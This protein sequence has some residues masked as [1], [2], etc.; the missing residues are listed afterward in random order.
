M[1]SVQN[2]TTAL[3]TDNR[4]P[5]GLGRIKIQYPWDSDSN[6]SYWARVVTFMSG[7]D[8]GSCFLS[9][10]ED[11]VLVAFLDGNIEYPIV[12]GSLWNQD[13]T[14]PYT[15]D[16]EE[17]NIRAIKS[18]SGHEIIFND[19]E[20]SEK[21]EIKSSKGQSVVLDDMNEKIKI[22]DASGNYIEMDSQSNSITIQS[23]MEINI[24]AQSS[25]KINAG[26]DITIEGMNVNIKAGAILTLEGAIVRIN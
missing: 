20:G 24:N 18:R 12:V 19:E 22:E 14:P 8:F 25:I 1:S 16:S 17:N 4:D 21:L 2:F 23:S 7:D 15:N 5:D 11:E 26:S 6:E 13:N 10:I 9:E 3:V